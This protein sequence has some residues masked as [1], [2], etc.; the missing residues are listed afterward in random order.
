[1]DIGIVT[2]IDYSNYG[3]RLQNY[4]VNFLLESLGVHADTLHLTILDNYDLR[5]LLGLK[6]RLYH[7]LPDCVGDARYRLLKMTAP[8][9]LRQKR[10]R[11]FTKEHMR[12]RRLKYVSTLQ[13]AARLEKRYDLFVTG[14]D[15]VWNPVF[16]G[17]GHFFLTFAPPG[18]RVA[19]AASVGV[20]SLP[21]DREEQYRRWMREMRFISVREEAAADLAEGL[22]GKRPE[23]W[24]D[25][26]LLVDCSVWRQL[27]RKPGAELP[28]RYILSFFLGEEPEEILTGYAGELGLPV[29]RLENK[30]YPQ[31]YACDPAEFLYMVDRAE[32]V[33]TDSFHATVFAIKFHVPF[34]V[35]RRRQAGMADM[36]N[37]IEHLLERFGLTDRYRER[38]WHSEY[39]RWQEI[40][41]AQYAGIEARIDR[42]RR[43]VMERLESLLQPD[44]VA[45]PG[46]ARDELS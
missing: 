26:T 40:T 38:G 6:R 11:K 29:I 22:T 24:P 18:K 32:L 39:S 27:A 12:I 46:N 9:R 10:F 4:A 28:A 20:D 5:G 33:L 14:S 36:F 15:Q 35:F 44:R 16:G 13:A 2:L 7:M 25:P 8:E 3:N 19:L 1:M 31:Y 41:E 37:R 23:V 30:K 17:D 45:G 43:R 42:E 21:A 34:F